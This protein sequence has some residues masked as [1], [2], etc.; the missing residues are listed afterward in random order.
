MTILPHIKTLLDDLLSITSNIVVK[1][2]DLANKY[3]DN[4]DTIDLYSKYKK[5]INGE[6]DT[7]TSIPIDVLNNYCDWKYY[8]K[9]TLSFPII[10]QSIDIQK[11]ENVFDNKNR[12]IIMSN[13]SP[14]KEYIGNRGDN[15]VT[16]DISQNEYSELFYKKIITRNNF[17]NLNA[18]NDILY[19][20]EITNNYSSIYTV[21]IRDNQ[22]DKYVKVHCYYG[23]EYVKLSE[24]PLYDI[25]KLLG[26][27]IDPEYKFI[28]LETGSTDDIKAKLLGFKAN[29]LP[30]ETT[31]FY[32]TDESDKIVKYVFDK[33][34]GIYRVIN[35][36]ETYPDDEIYI[37]KF[38]YDYRFAD[39]INF[40]NTYAYFKDSDISNGNIPSGYSPI[41]NIKYYTDDGIIFLTENDYKLQ[42]GYDI[43]PQEIDVYYK[44]INNNPD[45]V[46]KDSAYTD[47]FGQEVPRYE[48]D[49]YGNL[50]L[51]YEL[52]QG[53]AIPVEMEQPYGVNS[54]N[55]YYYFMAMNS[56]YTIKT[57]P[58]IYMRETQGDIVFYTRIYSYNKGNTYVCYNR[59]AEIYSY[60]KV[61]SSYEIVEY[62]K[63]INS[64]PKEHLD[65]LIKLTDLWVINSYCPIVDSDDY[66]VPLYIGETNRYYRELNGLPPID[67]LINQPK[68]NRLTINPTYIGSDYDVYVYMLTD[69][70]IEIIEKNGILD[71]YKENY[72]SAKYLWYLGKNRIDVIKA[73]LA[74]PYDILRHGSYK[75]KFSYVIFI[76]SY[77]LSKE[78]ILRR[79]YN[80]ELYDLHDEYCSYIG[81]IILTHCFDICM[82][83]S[84]IILTQ[85]LYNDYDTIKNKLSEYGFDTTFDTIPL[86]YREKI[87][88]NIENL[89]RNKGVNTVYDVIYKTFGIDSLEVFNYYFKKF[90]KTDESGNY[91]KDSDGNYVYDISIF[92]SPANSDSLLKNISDISNELSYDEITGS[93]KYWGV[94]ESDESV[95][96]KILNHDF[97]YMNSK[98]ITI[99]NNFNLSELNFT[100][101]YLLNYLLDTSNDR[102]TLNVDGI[103][104]E[105]PLSAYLIALFAIQSEKYGYSGLVQS[106]I[107]SI[108]HILKFNLNNEE[109]NGQNGIIWKIINDYYESMSIHKVREPN[110]NEENYDILIDIY[111]SEK[112]GRKY[113]REIKVD[114]EAISKP[115]IVEPPA[116]S[117]TIDDLGEA[118]LDNLT[119][120]DEITMTPESFYK[121]ILN[122][123]TNASN[124]NDYMCYS[125]ILRCISTANSV[126]NAYKLSTPVW[127]EIGSFKYLASGDNTYVR[128]EKYPNE[129]PK[130][131]YTDMNNLWYK[132]PNIESNIDSIISNIIELCSSI[133]DYYECV[134][135]ADRIPSLVKLNDYLYAVNINNYDG[136]ISPDII[137]GKLNLDKL[138][139]AAK[140]GKVILYLPQKNVAF[141]D[142]Y[143]LKIENNKTTIFSN[144]SYVDYLNETIVNSDT[145]MVTG[146][147]SLE[148]IK[149]LE[150]YNSISYYVQLKKES[151]LVYNV[152]MYQ[153]TD[154]ALSYMMY[155][156]NEASEIYDMIV[157]KDG[158]ENS[159]YIERINEFYSVIIA[160]MDAAIQKDS[161]RE[162]LNI[163]YSDFANIMEYIKL[164]LDVFKSYTVDISR[165]DTVYSISDETNNNMKIL[166]DFSTHEDS[167]F[168]DH[169]NIYDDFST[170]E[171]SC[172]YDKIKIYDELLILNEED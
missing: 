46:H 130:W 47:S 56:R 35:D 129:S 41:D 29:I 167:Y 106:D 97:N 37:K 103:S 71:K 112:Y 67:N 90:I 34:E 122:L 118:Y 125:K 115:V 132:V 123:K 157:R 13:S 139:Q 128:L 168:D 109:I 100:V 96:E 160:S 10:L 172:S 48:K 98:Y 165:L 21:Y 59:Y 49:Q 57:L 75:N 80:P 4:L 92:Q 147:E 161:L 19:T 143:E 84:D 3:E 62:S 79:F 114:S 50:K 45:I 151:D 43:I 101:S 58:I 65:K 131:N 170:H 14:D 32:D 11:Q 64:I 30:I 85:N 25:Y 22:F 119:E 148:N 55:E 77:I 108:A 144:S 81:F 117:D 31:I 17:I 137:D 134:Y 44:Y 102:I 88:K 145:C 93:D 5:L 111:N 116:D 26:T 152:I 18:N 53:N 149:N 87:A 104:N 12:K 7:Y 9:N 171:D 89:V 169:C 42:H 69:S 94:Y 60:S 8:S 121:K 20:I 99:N 141:K 124:V 72:P 105:Y 158:E 63:D 138:S 66:R 54:T 78:Y 113:A 39:S 61:F 156:K 110:K 140:L 127:E 38:I 83:H 133:D 164:V 162:E 154:V 166:D 24:L 86:V 155:L 2:S 52:S 15:W 150:S 136:D 135:V 159:L 23:Y 1:R 68:I 74:A 51:Y 6:S 82:A 40:E 146:T 153:K 27:D 33:D 91:I 70:E 16:F 28:G 95:K 142:L 36:D 163:I 73:R 120:Y 126:S 107:V 76:D